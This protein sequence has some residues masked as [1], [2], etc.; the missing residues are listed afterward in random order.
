MIPSLKKIGIVVKRTTVTIE[1]VILKERHPLILM[2]KGEPALFLRRVGFDE[3]ENTV[4]VIEHLM[5]GMYS[6]KIL[7]IHTVH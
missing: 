1:P 2:D 6:G 3:K 4:F 7:N 5:N